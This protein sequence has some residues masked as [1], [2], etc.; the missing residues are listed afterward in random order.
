MP[1]GPV[2]NLHEDVSAVGGPGDVGQILVIS[3]IVS[4]EIDSGILGEIIDTDADILRIHASHRILQIH[5]R[6]GACGDV[7][8]REICHSGFVLP[9]EGKASAVWGPENAAVDA[10]FVSAGGVSVCDVRIFADC[11]RSDMLAHVNVIE[12][13]A[14]R[15]G[16][17]RSVSDGPVAFH[18]AVVAFS[19][20][21]R[22]DVACVLRKSL[23]KIFAVCGREFADYRIRVNVIACQC[24][25]ELCLAVFQIEE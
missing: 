21:I 7:Q 3:E 8:Q 24:V 14:L 10:E 2:Q 6:T 15:E 16:Q 13:L 1:L 18:R 5:E 17:C 20:R 4:L 25:A 22:S 23:E 11:N 9:V 19:C 12:A